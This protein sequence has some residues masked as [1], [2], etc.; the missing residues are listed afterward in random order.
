MMDD[1]APPTQA[2][3]S[4]HDPRADASSNGRPTR[5]RPK[6]D[7]SSVTDAAGSRKS[8]TGERR[9]GKS[10]FGVVLGTLNRAKIEDKQRMA[11]E[12]VCRYRAELVFPHLSLILFN[13]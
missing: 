13:S 5:L 4:A 6:L 11:S 3:A 12:A 10:I 2:E 1:T 8:A 9:K 7:L